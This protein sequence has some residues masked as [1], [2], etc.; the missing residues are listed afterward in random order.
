MAGMKCAYETLACITHGEMRSR[1]KMASMNFMDAFFML[2]CCMNRSYPYLFDGRI[3]CLFHQAGETDA[4]YI[5][6]WLF[7][8]CHTWGFVCSSWL[9]ILLV[10]PACCVPRAWKFACV[11]SRSCSCF[12]L[13]SNFRD[14]IGSASHRGRMTEDDERRRR[15]AQAS[16]FTSL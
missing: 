6:I 16:G 1:Y 5:V 10:M 14:L 12:W 4:T 13:T 11:L 9:G 8:S 3:R 2:K 15:I 7:V